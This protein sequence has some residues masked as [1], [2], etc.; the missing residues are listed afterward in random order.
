GCAKSHMQHSAIFGDIDLLAA[1]HLLHAGSEGRLLG[2]FDQE[3]H[4]LICDPI[5]GV[6]QEDSAGISRKSPAPLRVA[7][8]KSAEMLFLN[9][10]V[11][12]LKSLPSLSSGKRLY[13]FGCD[14]VGAGRH[15]LLLSS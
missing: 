2:E 6:I 15:S 10:L 4:G 3:I 12:S 7:R 14:L 1:E 8:E 13:A 9:L 5:L 11:V